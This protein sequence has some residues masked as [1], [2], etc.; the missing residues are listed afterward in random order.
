MD[1]PLSVYHLLI[2]VLRVVDLQS[3]PEKRQELGGSTILVQ[4]SN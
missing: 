1:F 3:T 4:K 2:D